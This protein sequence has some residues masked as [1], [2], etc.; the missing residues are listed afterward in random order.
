MHEITELL[1]KCWVDEGAR[2]ELFRIVYGHLHKLA[3]ASVNR[4]DDPVLQPTEL[5]NEAYARIFSNDKSVSWPDR[6]HFFSFISKVMRHLLIDYHRLHA[7]AKRGGGR[8]AAP[9]LEADLPD[10]GYSDES[11]LLLE[12][13][14]ELELFDAQAARVAELHYCGGRSFREIVDILAAGPRPAT[15]TE[16]DAEASWRLARA[17]LKRRLEGRP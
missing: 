17:W 2:T 8:P 10:A 12:L 13:F 5:V 15:I 1:S 3:R 9:L 11:F 14:D 4:W 16:A 7:A 6:A